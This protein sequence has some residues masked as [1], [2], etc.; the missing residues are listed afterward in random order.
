MREGLDFT[1]ASM[2]FNLDREHASKLTSDSQSEL[3][4]SPAEMSGVKKKLKKKNNNNN[5]TCRSHYLFIEFLSF[6]IK[7]HVGMFDVEMHPY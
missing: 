4:D 7:H 5:D 3:K 2:L 1:E 6:F